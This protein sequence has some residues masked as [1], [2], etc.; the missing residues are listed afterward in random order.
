MIERLWSGKNGLWRLLT[1]FSVIYALVS[2]LNRCLYHWGWRR[3]YRAPVPVVVVGNLTVG[4]NGKTPVVIWLT[5]YLQKQGYHPAVVSRG[6]GGKAKSYPLIV[7]KTTLP[8]QAGDEPIVIYQRTG[9]PVAVAPDRSAAVRSLLQY[10]PDIDVII[11]DDGL[12]HYALQR[13]TEIVVIDGER[14]FGN[15]WWIPAG[16]MREHR[17]RLSTV[18]A[19]IVNGGTL[20]QSEISMQLR[21]AAAINL[22]DGQQKDPR[23]FTDAVAMAGIG[24]PPRFFSMLRQQGVKISHEVAFADHKAYSEAEVKSVAIPSKPLLM[25][26]KDAVKCRHFAAQNWWYIPVDAALHGAELSKLLTQ[27]TTLIDGRRG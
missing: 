26:E 15:G 3:S 6:Y 1:P 20:A 7:D 16:P 18:D 25:T 8:E 4:G 21:P 22:Y 9:A 17:N 5:D 13:D 24:Y 27:I 23:Q 14:R 19:V 12:Q 10:D 11:T 2:G